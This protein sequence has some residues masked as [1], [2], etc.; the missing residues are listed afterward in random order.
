MKLK[1]KKQAYQTCAV[2]AVVD[3]FKGQSNVA[4]INYRIDPG[5]KKKDTQ[6]YSQGELYNDSGFKNAELMLT[7]QQI[8]ENIQA[9]QRRQNLSPSSSLVKTEVSFLNLDI[10]METGTGKTYC[11][12][13]T[14]F[15]MNN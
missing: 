1:F 15:E 9:V 8:L 7:G 14:F 12:I 11:Y 3:C 13:K 4:G 6:G 5:V 2:E 10:E